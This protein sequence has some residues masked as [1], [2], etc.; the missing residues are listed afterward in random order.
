VHFF[1]KCLAGGVS[2]ALVLLW[3]PRLAPGISLSGWLGRGVAFTL[4]F[5]LLLLALRPL[6]Q[7]LWDTRSGVR[8][9]GR[10]DAHADRLRSGHTVRRLSSTAAVAAAA[11]AVPG[12]LI[13]AGLAQGPAH[14][15]PKSQRAAV[16]VVHIT[17]VV[18][19]VTVRRVVAASEPPAVVAP[20]IAATP[21]GSPP[22]RG[23]A[24][25]RTRKT[26]TPV[27]SPAREPAT[28]RESQPA[29]GEAPTPEPPANGSSTKDTPERQTASGASLGRA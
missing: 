10:I 28:P 17:K 8:M 23:T 6:E 15:N 20:A 29:E 19:P 13:A 12:L 22:K 14:T 9:R 16:R 2:A 24:A 25:P 3:W 18:R 11:L 21:R 26:E 5:E 27:K 1:S 7:T 4:T